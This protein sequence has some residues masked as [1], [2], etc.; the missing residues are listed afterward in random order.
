MNPR[1]E[2]DLLKLLARIAMFIFGVVLLID[3]GL[4]VKQETLQVDRH[5]SSTQSERTNG[6]DSTWADT[7]Y[8]LHL[9]GG[10]VSSCSVGYSAYGRLK[11]GD[12]VGISATKL[13]KTCTRITKGD[14]L[15]EA[16]KY[17]R[18]FAFIGGC[19]LIAAAFGWVETDDDGGFRVA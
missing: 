13:F 3:T 15:I 17:W 9:V 8:T 18:I 7:S 6:R 11:D 19:L 5:T 10:R 2:N 12:T 1:R 16:N 4:P 14:E